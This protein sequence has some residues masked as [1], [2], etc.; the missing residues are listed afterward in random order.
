MRL[1]PRLI[2]L[3]LLQKPNYHTGIQ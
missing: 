1:A 2:L 3:T